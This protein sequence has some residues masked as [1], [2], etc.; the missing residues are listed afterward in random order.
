[1]IVVSLVNSLSSKG[2]QHQISPNSNTAKSLLKNTRIEEVI[3]NLGSFDWLLI[4]IL[5]LELKENMLRRVWRIWILVLGSEGLTDALAKE[6]KYF[7]CYVLAFVMQRLSTTCYVEGDATPFW[8]AVMIS[9][10]FIDVLLEL[11]LLIADCL[12]HVNLLTHKQYT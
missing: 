10:C 11:L 2:D 7:S 8:S 1:M 4:Q 3:A 6:E 5:F 9:Y 12:T